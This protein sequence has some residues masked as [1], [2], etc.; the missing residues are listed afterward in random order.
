MALQS[1]SGANLF[2]IFQLPLNQMPFLFFQL[3]LSKKI[4]QSVRTHH[5]VPDD[6]YVMQL[7]YQN[8]LLFVQPI[9]AETYSNY[10]IAS[11]MSL[12]L[13]FEPPLSNLLNMLLEHLVG[14]MTLLFFEFLLIDDTAVLVIY[15]ASGVSSVLSN[16]SGT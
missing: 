3:R 10:V 4:I 1:I 14:Q 6:N 8:V 16:Y 2:K 11:Q 13:F 9:Y 12:S 15:S 5:F 7:L